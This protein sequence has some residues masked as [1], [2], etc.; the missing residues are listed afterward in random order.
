MRKPTRRRVLRLAAF[1]G[2]G[3]LLAW[4][5]GRAPRPAKVRR[6]AALMG[7]TVHL[8]VVGPDR[9]RGEA[10]AAAALARMAALEARLSRHRAD[11]EVG[12]LNRDG[13]L[14]DPSDALREVLALAAE[15]HALAG[16]AFDVTILPVL[17]LYRTGLP[18]RAALDA[19]LARVGQDALRVDAD[20]VRFAR[21]GM[22]LTLD[23]IGKGFVVD[24]G[25]A[26]LR[27]YG[28][29]RV[30]V[31]AGGDLFAAGHRWRIGIRHPRKVDSALLGRFE[32]GDL[33]VA[34]SGDYFQPFTRD[35]SRHHI[36]DPRTGV[37]AP[38]LCSATVLA[39][40]AARADGLAT[41]AMTLDPRAACDLF[42]ALPGCD[43]LLVTK[44][45][46]VVRTTGFPPT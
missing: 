5:T 21:P 10:A 12:R 45:G 30:L 9:A 32:A 39:P 43:A 2:A 26:E 1:A 44:A 34:T 29:A 23:G 16:G 35:R 18:S 17:D 14:A 22:A 24:A 20:V 42:E 3:G 15:V 46:D 27:R 4:W 41:L 38:G 33:A 19:A 37:S 8:T 7:T 36:L 40:T 25:V 6:T 13:T 28:F 31:E 11:S